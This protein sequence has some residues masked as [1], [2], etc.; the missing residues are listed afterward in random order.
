MTDKTKIPEYTQI[1]YELPEQTIARIVMARPDL[2]N[3]Q[4]LKMLYEINHAFDVA[5]RDPEVKVIILAGDGPHFSSGHDLTDDRTSLEQEPVVQAAGHHEPGAAGM[6]AGEEEY[7]VGLHWK[8][9]NIAKPTI[10]QVQGKAMAGGMMIAMPMDIIVASEDAQF[11]DP[12]VAFGLNGHEYFLHAWDLGPRKAKEMLFTGDI[13]SAEE[14]KELGMVNHVVP[15]EQLEEATLN[16]ARRIASR[17]AI[18]LKLAKQAINF[19]MDLQGQHQALTG[20]LAMHHV[21]HAHA[22]I[23]FGYAVDP[24]GLEVIQN[25]SRRAMKAENTPEK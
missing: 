21:G 12:V 7:Y 1:R 5:A 9:R 15:R 16:L 18:G 20:A 11:S 23:E 17:P 10:A 8:W 22:R 4:S 14:C 24:S 25:D 3:A 2:R 6:Y 13:L 19:S